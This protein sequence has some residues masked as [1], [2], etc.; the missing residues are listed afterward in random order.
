MKGQQ[1]PG[2]DNETLRDE[3]LSR[4]RAAMQR[5]S[6]SLDHHT[7]LREV[8]DGARALAGARYGVIATADDAGQPLDFVTSGLTA[9]EHRRLA[10]WP[11]GPRLFEHFRR[12]PG[13]R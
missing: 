1:E 4:L 12:L 5:I 13:H 10:G 9:D 2:R 8:L 6:A 11:D 7:V 3:R